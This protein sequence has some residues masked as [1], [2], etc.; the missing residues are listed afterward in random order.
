MKPETGVVI[1]SHGSRGPGAS[2]ADLEA[3]SKIL[4]AR[5]GTNLIAYAA[6]QFAH[7]TLA[8][9]CAQLAEKGVRRIV[10]VPFFLS[11][12]THVAK[13]IPAEIAQLQAIYPEIEFRQ[14][15][16][17]GG[18]ARLAEILLERVEEVCQNGQSR[19]L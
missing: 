3:I 11:T 4:A 9:A 12:G 19:A 5:L 6:L 15:R 7:P 13:D 8:E 17:L 1:L 2:L 10:V 18:D 14:A 16:H